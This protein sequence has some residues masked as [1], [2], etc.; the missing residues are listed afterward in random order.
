MSNEIKNA[1]LAAID[2]I[3]EPQNSPTMPD[4]LKKPD[5]A[6]SE[7]SESSLRSVQFC[8]EVEERTGIEVEYSDFLNNPTFL[9]FVAWLEQ[10]GG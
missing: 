7:L 1:V 8:M 9:G 3:F 5:F 4:V 6:F 10:R 2:E